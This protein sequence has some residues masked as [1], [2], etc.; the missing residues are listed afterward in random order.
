MIASSIKNTKKTDAQ[1]LKQVVVQTDPAVALNIQEIESAGLNKA[2]VTV[3]ALVASDIPVGTKVKISDTTNYNG[4][5]YVES[6]DYDEEFLIIVGAAV[7]TKPP[8]TLAA[9]TI[10]LYGVHENL[11]IDGT[12]LKNDFNEVMGYTYTTAGSFLKTKGDEP[13]AIHLCVTSGTL[14]AAF[15]ASINGLNWSTLNTSLTNI[16]AGGIAFLNDMPSGTLIRV[17]VTGTG[18]YYVLARG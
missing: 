3:D 9:G 8:Q 5:Y 7:D 4:I 11:F 17:N 14:S 6:A 13:L 12:E 2:K 15:Y 16:T 10:E 18:T 1:L